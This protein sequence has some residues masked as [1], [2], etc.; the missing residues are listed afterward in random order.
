MLRVLIAEDEVVLAYALTRQ[1]RMRGYEV[2][3]AVTDGQAAVEA[4]C[5]L[6][7]DV[8]FMDIRMPVMDGLEA[9][10]LIMDRCP[11][12]IVVITAF[13]DDGTAS[14]A[15]AVGAMGYLAKP[16][17]VDQILAAVGPA[18]ARFAQ[19]EAISREAPEAKEAI[20]A[21]RLVRQA[22]RR[23]MAREKV[24]EPDAFAHLQQLAAAHETTSAAA[25][26]Q[27][28]AG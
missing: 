13:G 10:R 17:T 22:V 7:P 15:E 6:H 21:W 25:A 5:A 3:R 24:S 1:L 20:D 14:Q 16:V 11:T 19:F 12:C 18:Q 9:T 28:L 4:C 26:Q 23:L 8:V 27:V 2:V